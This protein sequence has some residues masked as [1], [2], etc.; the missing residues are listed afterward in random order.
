[1][2]IYIYTIS[3]IL[4]FLYTIFSVNNFQKICKKTKKN[5]YE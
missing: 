3:K 4:Y 2:L 5:E 1:M